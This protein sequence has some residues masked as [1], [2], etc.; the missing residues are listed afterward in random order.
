MIHLTT[1]SPASGMTLTP[2][3]TPCASCARAYT[4]LF[5]D[6]RCRQCTPVAEWPSTPPALNEEA[7]SAFGADS[8]QGV[9]T[10]DPACF[11]TLKNFALRQDAVSLLRKKFSRSKVSSPTWDAYYWALRALED[12]IDDNA[13]LARDCGVL[14]HAGVFRGL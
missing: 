13:R 7:P 5:D 8:G 12:R 3:S 2:T 6:G 9:C 1:G 14:L 11:S 10:I 4:G